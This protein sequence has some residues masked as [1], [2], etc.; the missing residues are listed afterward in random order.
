MEET[1][2]TREGR[3]QREK[4]RL[5]AAEWFEE[6]VPQAE[7]ARRLGTSR[8]AVHVWHK[9]W[10]SGGIQA[11]HFPVHEA[12]PDRPRAGHR[13]RGGSAARCG[14]CSRYSSG[15]RLPG[16]L[17]RSSLRL[18]RS[19]AP[20]SRSSRAGIWSSWLRASRF[21]CPAPTDD[22]LGWSGSKRGPVT[23]TQQGGCT[24]SWGGR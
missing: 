14:T 23:V 6:G 7:V 16:H 3:L 5:Q 15:S 10:E 2:V 22:N 19:C 4:L 21:S 12:Q 1:G 11:L 13:R 18:S 8:Q 17:K 20:P 9:K 24:G